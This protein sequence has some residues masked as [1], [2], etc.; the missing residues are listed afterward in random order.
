VAEEEATANNS[1]NALI[2]TMLGV[3]GRNRLS[4]ERAVLAVV[5]V[6]EEEGENACLRLGGGAGNGGDGCAAEADEQFTH[7]QVSLS[8]HPSPPPFPFSLPAP[9]PRSLSFLYL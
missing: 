8:L 5:P 2:S 3:V 6:L 4:S 9:A 7:E 1:R